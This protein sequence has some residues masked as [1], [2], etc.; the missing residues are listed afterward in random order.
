[1]QMKAQPHTYQLVQHSAELIEWA[2]E[3]LNDLWS[4]HAKNIDHD[5]FTNTLLT[6]Q[7]EL[8]AGETS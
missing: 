8:Q 2:D 1:M 4:E 6:A 3:I 5:N 7:S